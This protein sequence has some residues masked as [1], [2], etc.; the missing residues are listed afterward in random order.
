MIYDFLLHLL[1]IFYHTLREGDKTVLGSH[2]IRCEEFIKD[3]WLMRHHVMHKRDSFGLSV[4]AR[5]AGDESVRRG[6][7]CHPVT[8]DEHVRSGFADLTTDT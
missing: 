2:E 4:S 1:Y 5:H 7:E 6:K 8:T 3:G